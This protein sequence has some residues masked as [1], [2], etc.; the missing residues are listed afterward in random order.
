MAGLPTN[1]RDQIMLAVGVVGVLL[2]GAF[3][4]LPQSPYVKKNDAM[5]ITRDHIEKL[6]A[7]NQK[8]KA[9]MAKGTVEELQAEAARL[10]SNL[11]V[12]RTLIPA[13]TEVPA[14]IDQVIGAARRTGLQFANFA[15]GGTVQGETFDTQRY[16]MSM[17]GT[18]N[19]IGSLLAEIGSLRRIVVPVNVNLQPAQG[20]VAQRANLPPEERLLRA[21]FAIQTYVVRTAPVGNP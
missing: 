13:G 16:N 4:G 2:A 5:Q 6:D 3:W 8:A 20:Q 7:S 14:L 9:I 17:N 19:Q 11:V 10:Q 18:Y 15:P 1:Q 21:T 12:M